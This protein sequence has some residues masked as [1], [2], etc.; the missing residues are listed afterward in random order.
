MSPDSTVRAYNAD[1]QRYARQW[2]GF[3]PVSPDK[4]IVGLL[5]EGLAPGARVLDVGSGSGRDL[6]RMC[7]LGFDITGLDVSEGLAQIAR[8]YAPVVVADM[9][10]MPFE[11]DSFDGVLAAASLLHL[12]RMEALVALKEIKRVLR[13]GGVL[14]LGVK[15][16]Q[17]E[18]TDS[19]GRYF[20]LYND[21]AIDSL[22]EF[23]GYDVYHR[24]TDVDEKRNTTWLIRTAHLSTE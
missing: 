8:Q 21:K 6:K 11:D 3:T 13:P 12:T 23:V 20:C 10:A 15:A 1:P 4:D 5:A 16:G 19:A 2:D 22:L 14:S 17:G 18:F 7:D 9:C 24:A